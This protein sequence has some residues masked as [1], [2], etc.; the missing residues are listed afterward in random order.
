MQ[1]AALIHRQRLLSIATL[2]NAKRR[3]E[4][5]RSSNPEPCNILAPDHTGFYPV[6]NYQGTTFRWSETA[7][8]LSFFELF[9]QEIASLTVARR[10]NGDHNPN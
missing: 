4:H 3:Q 10:A 6:E 1:L 9:T 7:L 2:R 5:Q 8:L